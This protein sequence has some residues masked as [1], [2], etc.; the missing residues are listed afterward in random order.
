MICREVLNLAS[1][2]TYPGMCI[3]T[4]PAG[5][6]WMLLRTQNAEVGVVWMDG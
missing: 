6:P 2:H 4:E 5:K 3:H 1:S